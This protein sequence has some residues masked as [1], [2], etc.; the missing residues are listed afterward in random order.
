MKKNLLGKSKEYRI[1]ND[2]FIFSI[3]K[4]I[5]GDYAMRLSD[6]AVAQIMILRAY[7][8]LLKKFRYLRV[9]GTMVNPKKLL[10]YPCDRIVLLEIAQQIAS[11]YNKVRK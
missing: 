2:S 4:F 7:Y 9:A 11:T 6:D 8:I 1:V 10:R 3:V 5:E